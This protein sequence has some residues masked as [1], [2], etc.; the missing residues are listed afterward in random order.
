M[1]RNISLRIQ[2]SI[3]LVSIFLAGLPYV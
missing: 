1:E 2:L 3:N